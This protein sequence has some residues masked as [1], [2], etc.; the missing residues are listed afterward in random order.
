MKLYLLSHLP[1]DLRTEYEIWA[2]C[3]KHAT[4]L[5]NETLCHNVFYAK[6]LT[7]LLKNAR[8]IFLAFY[9][10]KQS[11]IP[12]LVCASRLNETSLS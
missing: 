6:S 5:A 12:D 9:Q 2:I 4:S 3:S 8:Q 10:Q 11:S 1:V 7:F